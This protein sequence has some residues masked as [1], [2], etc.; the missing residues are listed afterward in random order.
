MVASHD[1]RHHSHL[2]LVTHILLSGSAYALQ[3]PILI[4]RRKDGVFLPH[5]YCLYHGLEGEGSI[6]VL[7]SQNQESKVK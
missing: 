4:K 6:N 5:I 1:H 3:L 2:H 7:F